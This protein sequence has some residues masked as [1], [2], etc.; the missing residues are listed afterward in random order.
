MAS[1]YMFTIDSENNIT[2]HP[3]DPETKDQIPLDGVQSFETAAQLSDIL[4]SS[5]GERAVEIWNSLPGV[6]PITSKKFR[7]RATAIDRIWKK[8]TEQ[9]PDAIPPESRA[10]TEDVPKPKA[11]TKTKPKHQAAKKTAKPKAERKPREGGWATELE[12]ELRKQFQPGDTFAL[13]DI[14]KLIP[15]FQRRHKENHHIAARLRTTLAQ[16]LRA[17]SIVKQTG[18]GKYQMKA[19]K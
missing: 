4:Y 5:P 3:F 2:A 6:V 14:Y 7:N 9:W 10:T 8:L 13:A 19:A 18:K 15:A 1:D 11:V 17:K 12:A 16:D